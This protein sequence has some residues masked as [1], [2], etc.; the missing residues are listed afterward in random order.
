[1]SSVQQAVH[2]SKTLGV[3]VLA[4]GQGTRMHSSLPK[5][6]HRLAGRSLLHHV[7]VQVAALAPQEVVVVIPP[8]MPAIE[9][10]AQPYPCVVQA[11]P[12]G[13]GHAVQCAMSALQGLADEAA[14]LVLYADTPL[15]EVETL[16]R[17]VQQHQKAGAVLSVMAMQLADA[18]R[19]GRVVLDQTGQY[20]EKI[21]EYNDANEQE[22][23]ISLA[24]AGMMLIQN[25]W[26]KQHIHKLQPNNAKGEFYLTDLVAMARGLGLPVT[27]G[28]LPEQQVGGINTRAE[29]AA[30][31]A[32]MQQ[33]LRQRALSRGV[34]LI[35]PSSVYFSA[36]TVI[37]EDVT[38]HPHVYFGNNVS[39]GSFCEILPFCHLE[40]VDIGRNSRI[41]PFARLRPGA[42]LGE[43]VHIGNFVEIKNAQLGDGVKAGHLSY[44]GDATIGAGTNVGAGTITCNYDGSKKHHTNIGERVFIGSNTAL[45]AP[46]SVGDGAYIGAGSVITRNVPAD[47]LAVVRG[48]WRLIENYQPAKAPKKTGT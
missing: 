12:R 9:Q 13:T 41:G 48:E 6:L 46:V 40:G 37:A 5:V 23:A 35:D 19:Y 43:G 18:G 1:M 25:G 11:P 24:N 26:L 14:I 45:I 2:I 31:E 33:R 16:E 42:V 34:T 39:I 27:H 29:L 21:V 17:L 22:R 4:A 32:V 15:L 7:L 10:A 30:A 36:D 28:L 3:V 38:I 44:L 8:D 47:S 20:V